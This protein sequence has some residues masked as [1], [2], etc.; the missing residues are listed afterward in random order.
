[1]LGGEREDARSAA[2][3][4]LHDD[5]MLN[6]PKLVLQGAP[7]QGKS[8][9]VQYVCQAHRAAALSKADD[10]VKIP[11]EL[12]PKRRCIP[13]KAELRDFATWLTKTNPFAAVGEDTP[14]LS[15]Q[16]SL[17]SFLAAL[18]NHESVDSSSQL[19]I[20]TL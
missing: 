16:P 5:A 3:F 10:L 14:L 1:V 8:T 20:C 2:E 18:I 6:S 7:G 15:G 17:E 11:E 4:L 9:I 13:I 12:R 19:R